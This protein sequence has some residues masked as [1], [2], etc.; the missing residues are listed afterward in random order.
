MSCHANSKPFSELT[1]K[2]KLTYMYQIYN[3]QHEDYM[4]QAANPALPE[5]QKE[6]LRKKKPILVTLQTLIPIYDQQVQLG[7]PS[8]VNEQKIY[9]LLTQLQGLVVQLE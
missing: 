7:N 5:A 2:E 9:N 4:A 8:T 1:S 6:I 3:A